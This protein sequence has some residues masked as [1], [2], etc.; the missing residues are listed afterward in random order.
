MKSNHSCLNIKESKVSSISNYIDKSRFL[1]DEAPTAFITID[2]NGIICNLNKKAKEMLSCDLDKIAHIPLSNYLSI[3]SQQTFHNHL[4]QALFLEQAQTFEVKIPVKGQLPKFWQF[5]LKVIH[6]EASTPLCLINAYDISSLKQTEIQLQFDRAAINLDNHQKR[7]FLANMSH[8]VRTP[9]ALILG[10]VDLILKEHVDDGICQQLKVVKRAGDNLLG[11][12]N[13]IVDYSKIEASLIEIE[14]HPFE[15]N[16]SL[17]HIMDLFLVNCKQRNINLSFDIQEPFPTHLLGDIERLEQILVNLISNAI[18]FTPENGSIQVLARY[19]ANHLILSIK[20]SGPGIPEILLER[21]FEPFKQVNESDSRN[22]D[23][24][25]LGLSICRLIATLMKGTI[26]ASNH[27]DGGAVFTLMLPLQIHGLDSEKITQEDSFQK[28]ILISTSDKKVLIIDDDEDMRDFI[29]LILVSMNLAFDVAFDGL[30][31]L[32]KMS[33]TEYD[34]ILLDIQMPNM[35][36]LEV[37]KKIR[38]DQKL[39]DN[40]VVALTA[41]VI[42]SQVEEILESG[43][44]CY[45]SKPIDIDQLTA[46]IQNQLIN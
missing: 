3:D 33:Q 9:M 6:F 42:K 12:L 10:H 19:E 8:E 30:E 39:M 22:E 41:Q 37:I 20:D 34:L 18:K 4:Q 45:L 40:Y 1:I 38:T 14:N 21:I 43:F 13:D 31:G 28:P 15:L 5:H 36:G 26:S 44:D 16:T 24:V 2:S 35:N 27:V 46:I 7:S 29:S 17:Q 32:T 25:G 23:G 11:I